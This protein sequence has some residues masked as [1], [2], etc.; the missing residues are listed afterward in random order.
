M[1]TVTLDFLAAQQDRILAEL[2]ALRDDVRVTAAI[3]Q[4]LDGTMTGALN[5]IRAE[6]AR[7][8]RLA[9]RIRRLEE[10]NRQPQE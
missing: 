4:R 5:E 1:A 7:S 3:V 8:D 6:H 9:E 10:E 2:A